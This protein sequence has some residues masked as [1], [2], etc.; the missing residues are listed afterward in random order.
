MN[1]NITTS[2]ADELSAL[3]ITLNSKKLYPLEG[4]IIPPVIVNPF[5]PRPSTLAL[6]STLPASP[7]PRD[8]MKKAGDIFRNE[9]GYVIE[10]LTDTSDRGASKGAFHFYSTLHPINCAQNKLVFTSADG[11]GLFIKDLQSKEI[12]QIINISNQSPTSY[13]WHPSNEHMLF[14][15][16]NQ[17]LFLYDV[18]K[19]DL[20]LWC[21]ASV[22]WTS[23]PLFLSNTDGNRFVMHYSQQSKVSL[24]VALYE[25]SSRHLRKFKGSTVDNAPKGMNLTGAYSDTSLEFVLTQCNGLYPTSLTFVSRFREDPLIDGKLM[26][27]PVPEA[28]LG[29]VT[30]HNV[31]SDGFHHRI[32][33]AVG[34][35]VG[36]LNPK[37]GDPSGS[38]RWLHA[39]RS[40]DLA[41][42]A[43][44]DRFYLHAA[45]GYSG[46]HLGGNQQYVLLSTYKE[47]PSVPGGIPTPQPQFL[48]GELVL[49][50]LKEKAKLDLPTRVLN[51]QVMRIA[52][53]GSSGMNYWGQP[54]AS[55]SA[56]GKEAVFTS[57]VSGTLQVYR[58]HL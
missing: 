35:P 1:I 14:V 5:E 25:Q 11:G 19:R 41:T 51:P 40:H 49:I 47:T 31:T 53:H 3:Q 56:S 15:C 21:D 10:Q 29:V 58:V 44:E 22:A 45:D 12:F 16:I 23:A 54:R 39:I 2:T 55:L 37:P 34:D 43:E 42:K 20:T 57:D 50:S 38:P 7:L 46:M 28:P 32:G 27:N 48:Q 13:V 33:G 24:G 52:S 9:Y 26:L 4:E 30:N 18:Q 8:A 6:S 36:A 17:Q